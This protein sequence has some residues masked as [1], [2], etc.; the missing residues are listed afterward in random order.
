MIGPVGEEDS[1]RGSRHPWLE[2][3]D[4][5]AAPRTLRLR[6]VVPRG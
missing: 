6:L 4:G 1:R 2:W 3:G 5:R